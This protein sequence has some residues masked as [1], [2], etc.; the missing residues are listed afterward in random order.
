M[1]ETSRHLEEENAA[2]K[3]VRYIVDCCKAKNV[4]ADV[5]QSIKQTMFK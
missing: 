5:Q 4:P 3:V 1:D 2:R